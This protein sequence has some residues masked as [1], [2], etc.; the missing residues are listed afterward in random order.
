LYLEHFEA[1]P[2]RSIAARR[3]AVNE[4][5]GGILAG[6]IPGPRALHAWKLDDDKRVRAPPPFE[7]FDRS[8]ADQIAPAVLCDRCGCS[9]SIGLDGATIANLDIQDDVSRHARLSCDFGMNH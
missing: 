8:A 2:A 5:R 3:G 1:A 7:R 4:E 6:A 9:R